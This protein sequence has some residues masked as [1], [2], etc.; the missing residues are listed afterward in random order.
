MAG[1]WKQR[2]VHVPRSL[3][4]Y[5]SECVLKDILVGVVVKYLLSAFVAWAFVS[6]T[7]SSQWRVHPAEL[8]REV[9][10]TLQLFPSR[11]NYKILIVPDQEAVAAEHKRIYG[12]PTPAPA[13]YAP[14]ENLIVIPRE[15][16][17]RVLRHEL[18]HAVVEAYFKAPV[19][20]WLHEKLA[21]HAEGPGP[22]S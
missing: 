10:K 17:V 9:S 21:Q 11:T 19:P 4:P 5:E 7:S 6:C 3:E 16:E 1:P 12:K 2:V 14:V 8:E 18:G 20:R 15:C 22:E 13:F